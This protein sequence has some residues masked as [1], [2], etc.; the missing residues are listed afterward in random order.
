[1]YLMD[2]NVLVYAYREDVAQHLV[3]HQWLDSVV[4]GSVAFGYSELV[5]SGFLQVVTHPKIFEIPASLSSAM[6]FV[7]QLRSAPN[8]ICIAPGSKHWSI[9]VNCLRD[10]DAT[11][12]HI[13]DAYHAALALEWHCMWVTMDKGFRRF[14]GLTCRS[15]LDLVAS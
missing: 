14:K 8:A 7:E 3:C 6:L 4:N 15:P 2:V 9:F 11:G 13:P 5:L 10:I 1:M 12:N